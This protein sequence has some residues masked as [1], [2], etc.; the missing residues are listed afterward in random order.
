MFINDT[1]LTVAVQNTIQKNDLDSWWEPIITAANSMAY[2]TIIDRLVQRGFSLNQ[3]NA[4]DR[5][6][7]FQRALGIFYA[8]NHPAALQNTV[9]YSRK[10]LDAFDRREELTGNSNK[11]IPPV[12]LVIAGVLQ[13]PTTKYGQ[14]TGGLGEFQPL[15]P[16]F[17][18]FGDPEFRM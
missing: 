4:W 2:N 11:K 1:D 16:K 13:E 10:N 9:D 5:G 3:I 17:M 12:M 14:V 15:S 7:E 18:L 8:L 6:A